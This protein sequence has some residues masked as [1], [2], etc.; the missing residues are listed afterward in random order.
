MDLGT[1]F[2][3][4]LHADD[5]LHHLFLIAE[6]LGVVIGGTQVPLLRDQMMQM[7]AQQSSHGLL[8]PVRVTSQ[9]L[10]FFH[11]QFY[12]HTMVTRQCLLLPDALS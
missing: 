5:E 11:A 4:A 1:S 12:G 7:I 2:S 3:A 10:V 6:V 8:F 9:P